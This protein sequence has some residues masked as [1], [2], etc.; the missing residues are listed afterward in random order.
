M[1]KDITASE[2]KKLLAA[3]QVLLVDVREPAEHQ[4]ECIDG[5]CLIP[6]GDLVLDKLPHKHG[7]IV[8][9]CHSGKR[10]AEA[11]RRLLIED[12]TLEIYNLQGGI[13][14]WKQSGGKISKSGRKILPLD[15]Q[16]QLA[17]G[18]LSFVGTVCAVLINTWFFII[19]GFVGLGLMFA[20]LSGWCGM[21]KLLAI[22][23][24]NK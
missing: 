14:S 21:A 17:A 15:R 1:I 19:P 22:M 23:P 13:S 8:V 3:G 2:L 24:W 20:G 6:L 16:T 4:T 5:A 9:H 10:S 12:P 11:C 18:V 7:K